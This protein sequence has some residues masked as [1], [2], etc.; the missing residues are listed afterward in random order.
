MEN[1]SKTQFVFKREVTIPPVTEEVENG[2]IGSDGYTKIVLD[3]FDVERVIRTITMDNGTLL[4]LL[5]DLHERYETKA[6][7]HPKTG[8]PVFDK[9]GQMIFERLKDAFQSEITLLE[10]DAAEFLSL[11]SINNYE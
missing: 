8:A 7:T 2:V 6:K 5:D 9:K 3:S 1:F 11:T 4:V 10:E